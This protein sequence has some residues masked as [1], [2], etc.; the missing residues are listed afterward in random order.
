MPIDYMRTKAL[1]LPIINTC[2][3]HIGGM[4]YVLLTALVV[5]QWW[6]QG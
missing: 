6:T 3:S 2:C 1:T 4:R 5:N